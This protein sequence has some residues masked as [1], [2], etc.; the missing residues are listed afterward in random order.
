MSKYRFDQIAI[1]S[2]AKKKPTE[3]DKYHYIGL[4]HIDSQN[5]IVSRWGSEIAPKG[6]KLL[7]KKGDVLFGK[8]RAYQKK[9]AIAPFDGIFSA[10]GMVLRPNEDVVDKNFFPM[11]ISSDYFLDTAIA[12]SVGSL[13][14]TI[15]WKDL[16]RLEF[17]LPPMEEQRKLAEVL[18]SINDTLQAYQK[19]LTETDALVQAQF[20][21]MFGG[22]TKNQRNWPVRT[23]GEIYNVTSSKRIYARELSTAGI[24]F[25][26]VADVLERIE[27]GNSHPKTFIT[28][29]KFFELQKNDLVP[30][31]GDILITSR[32]T[33]GKCYVVQAHDKFYFQDGMISWLRVKA[34][35]ILLS[36]FLLALFNTDD[37][38]NMIE[39]SALKTTVLY[40]SL[41][42]LANL[43]VICP[44]INKQNEYLSFI[45]QNKKA[46]VTLQNTITSL[47]ATKRC[48]LE[49]ALGTGRKE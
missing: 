18:W 4:E 29:Q 16:A 48:I 5:L 30:N 11:F 41:D 42:K 46:K 40:L 32:G 17:D 14:P 6:E 12:I 23:L 7:M 27:T 49:N 44:P 8:R 36:E 37:F 1:N 3:E 20:V 9:V 28:E 15:N 38:C 19:L 35:N 22:I 10:H 39:K 43:K 2:T 33:I 25:L 21:E 26:K 24:P 13:S 47:Q 31:P 34:E 45:Q